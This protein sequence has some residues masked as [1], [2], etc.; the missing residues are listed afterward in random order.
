M[1]RFSGLSS[2][3]CL[4]LYQ[5]GGAV[6]LRSMLWSMMLQMNFDDV[7]EFRCEKLLKKQNHWFSDCTITDEIGL[8]LCCFE[9][10]SLL[11]LIFTDV[12]WDENHRMT[13]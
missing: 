12:T 9:V 4:I 11:F 13:K 8:K 3:F 5:C 2:D 10:T 1:A 6:Q 7:I